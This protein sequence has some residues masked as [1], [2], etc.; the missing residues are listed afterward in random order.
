MAYGQYTKCVEPSDYSGPFL[1]STAFYLALA[2]S[3]V[4]GF[5]DPGAGVLGL[6]ATGIAYCRWWLYGRLICL[7]GSR[8]IIGLALGVYNQTNQSG[9][10][11]LDTDYG[12]NILL[13]PSQLGDSIHDVATTNAVQGYFVRDQRSTMAPVNAA[14]A[15][16]TTTFNDY[17]NLGFIGEPESYEDLTGTVG[18][19]AGQGVLSTGEAAALGLEPTPAAWQANTFYEPGAQVF[20]S[21][22]CVQNCTTYSAGLSGGTAPA[23]SETF[24]ALTMDNAVQWSCAGAPG[25]GTIEVEFEG[26]GVWDLYVALLAASPVAAAAAVVGAIPFFGWLLALLLILVALAIVAI[27][28]AIGL[29]DTTS[30]ESDDPS[31]GVIH[32]GEDI[33]F[34]MG[35]WIYDSGHQGWNELHPV[36]SCQKIGRKVRHADLAEGN[37]W[38]GQP[39]FSEPDRLQFR[40]KA[41][42]KLAMNAQDPTTRSNQRKRENGWTLHP[43]VD[44]CAEAPG[45]GLTIE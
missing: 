24:G 14:Q 18:I 45:A 10:G 32:P 37:P 9:I 29:G 44:G 40:L 28:A 19:G 16:L 43:A 5:F 13:A 2:A 27:G 30:P 21:N 3:I 34:V 31:I 20:D 11:K 33:L 41:M 12:V 6:I 4:V 26:A 36:L 42:C 15:Q 1:Y 22:G 7:G 23:W 25:V 39:E 38:A 8:C 17:S 35:H